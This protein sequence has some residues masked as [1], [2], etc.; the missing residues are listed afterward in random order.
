MIVCHFIFE[1]YIHSYINIYTY[2]AYICLYLY[3]LY[4]RAHQE[5]A[6]PQE[7]APMVKYAIRG[8]MALMGLS[9]FIAIAHTAHKLGTVEDFLKQHV[10]DG[11]FLSAVQMA[12]SVALAALL[13]PACTPMIHMACYNGSL[14]MGGQEAQRG[15][16]QILQE[17]FTNGQHISIPVG[18]QSDIQITI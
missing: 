12:A 1:C 7:Q 14:G 8:V 10:A 9:L 11:S 18:A 15:F 2:I 13:I 17:G 16:H 6:A 4:I 5:Q 3:C